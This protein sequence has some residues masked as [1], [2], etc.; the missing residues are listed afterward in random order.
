MGRVL[1][2]LVSP[3]L[4]SIACAGQASESSLERLIQAQADGQAL[5]PPG[6][7]EDSPGLPAW[8]RV[9]LRKNLPGL[10][11]SGQPRYPREAVEV[12]RWLQANPTVAEAELLHKVKELERHVPKVVADNERRSRY[13]RDW[14][15]P[16][17]PD[18]ALAA[19]RRQLEDRL[20]LLP[21]ADLEDQT[22][23]PVWF[24]VYLR[25]QLPDLA[26]SGP[27][28]YPRTANRMLQRLLDHPSSVEPPR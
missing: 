3:A 4:L 27:Y 16:V 24:R 17:P 23:L 10:P 12:L 25:Q 5:L 15:V 22:P 21:A 7:A 18:T 20:D 9:L 19:L 13:P 11:K 8:F 26:R 28:Q 2:A 6:D 14:E 1:A